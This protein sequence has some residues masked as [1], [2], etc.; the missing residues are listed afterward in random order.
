MH[1]HAV[2][3]STYPRGPRSGPGCSVRSAAYS[4]SGLDMVSRITIDYVEDRTKGYQ[5]HQ[6]LGHLGQTE[7]ASFSQRSSAPPAAA[8]AAI[9]DVTAEKVGTVAAIVGAAA[10]PK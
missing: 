8:A 7:C 6:W 4:F 9:R 10:K 2:E 3:Y 5:K 1:R